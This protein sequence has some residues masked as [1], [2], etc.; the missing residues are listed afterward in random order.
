MYLDNSA[1]TPLDPKVLDAMMPWL[2]S[3]FGNASSVH[4]YGRK[5]RIAVEDARTEIAHALGAHPAELMFTSGGT[6]SNNTALHSPLHESNLV[7]E[8]YCTAIEHHSVLDVVHA[9]KRKGARADVIDVD[10][11]G[12]VALDDVARLDNKRSLI[13]VM[14]VN[15]ETG[16]VQ[17]ITAVRRLLPNAY[18]HTDAVQALGKV[19]INVQELGVDLATFSAHKIHGP[20]GIG[21]LFVRRGIDFKPMMVGGG[22]ERNRRAGTENV[23]AIV[24]F[25]H[26][27]RYAMSE[28]DVR[29]SR[30]RQLTEQLRSLIV[31]MVPDVRFNT[32]MEFA[33]P[34]ILNVSFVDAESLDGE[35]ILQLLDMR[36]VAASNG[37]ACVS[38]SQQPSHVLSA[39][40]LGRHEARA[41]LRLSVSHL[42]TEEE[43]FQAATILSEVIRDLRV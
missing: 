26:A 19:R 40:G 13:S 14:L 29:T 22:Q 6:E 37:S 9:L 27:V 8:V 7:D 16:C 3:E 43:I 5:A 1:T 28:F 36:N 31:A 41:A 35:A 11:H 4:L 12:R 33:A 18:L 17:D 24:G 32:P 15:N 21:A 42:T 34:H 30:M 23:A 39:M 10:A 25:Q 20:K 38:G 2:T